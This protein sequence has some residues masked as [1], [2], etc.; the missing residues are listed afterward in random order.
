MVGT[1]RPSIV[2]KNFYLRSGSAQSLFRPDWKD[3]VSQLPYKRLWDG[4][5]EVLSPLDNILR[6]NLAIL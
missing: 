4:M 6:S 5:A 1:L 3:H 2:A